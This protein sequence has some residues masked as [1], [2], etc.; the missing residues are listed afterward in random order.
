MTPVEAARVISKRFSSFNPRISQVTVSVTEFN[1]RS[2]YVLGGIAS[3]GRYGFEEIPDLPAVLTIA[4]GPTG[5]AALSSI[6]IVRPGSG[7]DG[8][9]TVDLEKAVSEGDL[10][11][12]P[13][14]RS[15]DLIWI[16]TASGYAGAN[17]VSVLGQVTSPG[18]YAIGTETDVL[19]LILAAGGPTE[20]ADLGRVRLMRPSVGVFTIDLHGYLERGERKLMPRPHR[21]DVLVVSEKSRFWS[22]LWNGFRDTVTAAAAV[23]AVYLAYERIVEE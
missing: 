22:D 19:D 12:L 20:E 15:G 9:L 13:A 6:L 14:L 1:F 10:S 8:A 11:S 17:R 4:G 23:L 5:E 21:D 2:V 3:P 7:S 16:P 18:M